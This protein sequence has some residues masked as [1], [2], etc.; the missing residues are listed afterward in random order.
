M[1]SVLHPNAKTTPRIRKEIQESTES[2]LLL[3]KRYSVN[4]KTI[5]RWR[6]A[7]STQDS[8]SG[9]KTV[10][11]SLT[12]QEQQIICEVR[13]VSRLSLDDLYISMK[14][15]IKALTR[16]NLH[17]LLCRN[18]LNVLPKEEVKPREKK[19]FKDYDIGFLHI[20]ITEVVIASKKKLYIFVSIDRKSKYVY[21]EIHD[22]KRVET[23]VKFLRNTIKDVPFKVDKIL[24]DN[25]SQF[26]YKLLAEHL[27]PKKKHPFDEVCESENIEHRLTQFRHPWTNGQVEVFNRVLK[28]H[29]TKEY[30]YEKAEEIKRHVMSFLLLYN[31]ERPLRRLNYVSPVDYLCARYRKSPELFCEN[32]Y[33]KIWGLNTYRYAL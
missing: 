9:P 28:D 26:T 27:R 13:R 25:G 30:Y 31:F 17:R 7:N 8:K 14:P 19:K 2:A 22:N 32:P 6:R 4:V 1:G 23:A 12:E 20:D 21:I 33:H 5:Y 15:S 29:T 16:S 10:R 24:T 3:A 18:N 11:S